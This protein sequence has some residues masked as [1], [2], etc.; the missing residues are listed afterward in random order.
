MTILLERRGAAE[1][2]GYDRLL[3]RPR[4]ALVQRALGAGF[5]L[6]GGFKLQD[7][8]E[9]LGDRPAFD[10]VVFSGVM[11]H[12]FD[13]FGGLATVRGLVRDG[14][15]C[16]VE[17]TI[18]FDDSE[19]MHFNTA[20]RFTPFALWFV[21]PRLLDYLLRFLRLKP[22]DVV[23]LGVPATPRRGLRHLLAGRRDGDG[24]PPAQGRIAVACRA[25][26]DPVAVGGDEWIGG[27]GIHDL[28]FAEFLDWDAVA[29]DA[30]EVGYEGR[31]RASC[32][33]ATGASTWPPRSPPRSR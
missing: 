27:A 7:L 16:V 31:A 5:E 14:G 30:G 15:I 18:V 1:V 22:I 19:A 23:H 2:V 32:A 29:S 10:V 8:P 25:M 11:Y 21:T 24:A 33:A 20:G 12:M 3:R 28:D 17:T 6:V 26:A 13:P 9:A 4:L